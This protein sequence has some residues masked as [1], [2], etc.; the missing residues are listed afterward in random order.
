VSRHGWRDD[1]LCAST[2]SVIVAFC[3]VDMPV[4]RIHEKT[5][6]RWGLDAVGNAALFWGW[7]GGSALE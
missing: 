3:G 7:L 6:A 5:Y 2:A 1:A 4:C